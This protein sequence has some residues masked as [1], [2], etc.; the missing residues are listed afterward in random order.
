MGETVVIT[1]EQF[2]DDVRQPLQT[3]LGQVDAGGIVVR[4]SFRNAAILRFPPITRRS[5][6]IRRSSSSLSSAASWPLEG[7]TVGARCAA[8]LAAKG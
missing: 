4:P 8:T 2:S 1:L 6:T 7:A 3:Q 5:R